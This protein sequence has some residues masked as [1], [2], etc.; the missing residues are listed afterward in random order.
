[1][2]ILSLGP[3]R[4]PSQSGRERSVV[5]APSASN[6]YSL[7]HN[8]TDP[9]TDASNTT[10]HTQPSLE[11]SRTLSRSLALSLTHNT[12]LHSTVQTVTMMKLDDATDGCC[13]FFGFFSNNNKDH[14][15]V[16]PPPTR[17]PDWAELESELTQDLTR[18]RIEDRERVLED[19]HGIANVA[20]EDPDLVERALQELDL[21]L[22]RKKRGTS[23]ELAQSLN[24]E[25]VSHRKLRLQFLR[26]DD[27]DSKAAADRLI[28]FFDNKRHL[29]GIDLLA[30]DIRLKD[31]DEYDMEAL[32]SGF[33][34]LA[35]EKDRAGRPV[36]VF[37]PALASYHAIENMVGK[38]EL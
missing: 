1:M 22:E 28:K 4:Q 24:R 26:A 5:V 11:R 20:D 12:T 8:Y 21:E 27:M 35:P 23:Y 6:S 10:P 18:M 36:I 14:R 38:M 15:L 33:S 25:Y 7:V 31:L 19:L 32:S 13:N 29:F 2:L 34:Q 30:K 37:V 3:D 9:T 16:Q 17:A